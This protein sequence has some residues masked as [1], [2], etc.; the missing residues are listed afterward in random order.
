MANE[1]NL[2]W[3]TGDQ[4]MSSDSLSPK[5]TKNFA[6]VRLVLA[7]A[8]IQAMISVGAYAAGYLSAYVV[9]MIA[10]TLL[11]FTYLVRP[12][13]DDYRRRQGASL[14]TDPV[15]V[16]I[17][18]AAASLALSATLTGLGMGVLVVGKALVTFVAAIQRHATG[19][20]VMVAL[21]AG[22]TI[23]VGAAF[24]YFRLKQRFVYGATEVAAGIVVAAH[25]VSLEPEV[26]V[27]SDTSFYFA[28]LTAGVYLVVRGLDNM[29][30]G[31]KAGEPVARDL[32]TWPSRLMWSRPRPDQSA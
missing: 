13:L 23:L 19:K 14:E 7:T 9:W 22:A 15:T 11:F 12:A 26:G 28:F 5:R 6:T 27:P 3:H 32:L 30:Q 2:T 10:S 17:G 29:H 18:V 16:V 4:P 8:F 24:F 25:R 1:Q 31:F 21:T 20:F